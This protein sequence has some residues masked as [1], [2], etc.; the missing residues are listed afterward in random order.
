MFSKGGRYILVKS[1]LS[2][3]LRNYFSLFEIA[4]LTRLRR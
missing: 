1:V 4:I 3:M 2:S